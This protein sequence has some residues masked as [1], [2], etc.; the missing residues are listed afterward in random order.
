MGFSFVF[1]IKGKGKVKKWLRG[2]MMKLV[3]TL[4][5]PLSIFAPIITLKNF[6]QAHPPWA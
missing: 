4:F 6:P 1:R 3:D 5:L 2:E